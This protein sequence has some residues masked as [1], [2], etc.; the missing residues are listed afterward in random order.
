VEE[1]GDLPCRDVAPDVPLARGV[2]LGPDV[3][4][5]DEEGLVG[6]A[7]GVIRVERVGP[8]NPLRRVPLKVLSLLV[9]RE[10]L[11]ARIVVVPIENDALPR[12]YLPLRLL[13][14]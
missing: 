5:I 6:H 1:L 3:G 10:E 13:H 12:L 11:V 2:E 14:R 9:E 7:E 4:A 8:V